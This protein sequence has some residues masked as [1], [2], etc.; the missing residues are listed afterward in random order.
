MKNSKIIYSLFLL[1]GLIFLGCTEE[2]NDIS[3]VEALTAPSGISALVSITQDNTGLVTFTPLGTGVSTYTII[4]GDDSES[5]TEIVPGSSVEHTYPEGTYDVTIIGYGPSGLQT[6]VVQS[7]VVS[8]NP[9]ENLDVI[10]ENDASISKQVNVIATADFAVSFD[11]Y[12]GEAEDEE[13]MSANIGETASYVYQEPGTY[14]IKVVT[15]GGAI[16]TTAYEEEFLVTEILQPVT[17]APTPPSRS[18]NDVISIYSDAYANEAGADYFPDWGQGGQGSSWAS[19]DLNGDMM[20]QYIN[21]SYQGI[22]LG[23]E[24]DLSDM[25]FLHMD[26]WTTD[27]T[28]IETSLIRPGPEER[29]FSNDLVADT[30]TSID[31]PISEYTDQGLTITD[32]FQLKFVGTPWAEG[33]VFID[34]IYFY[35]TPTEFIEF[36]IGFESATLVYDWTGFGSSSFGEIPA[37]VI[38]NPDPAGINTSDHVL[39][40]QKPSGA[41]VWAGASMPLSGA[42]DFSNGTT[43]TIKVWSPRSGVPVLFKMEDTTSPLDSNNNPTVFVEVQATTQ[44]S[45]A[46]EE[47][48][49]DLT[50]YGAFSTS[51][52]YHNVIIFPDFGNSGG[53]EN[54]Y[55]DDITLTN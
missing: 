7:L 6:E 19:F 17:P 28:S 47:L 14:S 23:A 40:I 49:F 35:R 15:K 2:E 8:F 34:N 50:S 52:S 20:L 51:T 29:P 42:A 21:L 39:E 4:F 41:Q 3:F 27:V 1:L 5:E 46:W 11:V 13:P 26:V 55:F 36:P 24:T 18:V 9:P 33:T 53:G 31:I 45:N 37:S 22:A 54:F 32:I 10:I 12:F 48:S 44:S 16:E 25:E 43:V 30:W 38:T